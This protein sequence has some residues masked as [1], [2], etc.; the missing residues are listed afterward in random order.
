MHV[1]APFLLRSDAWT[2]RPLQE[3]LRLLL[4]ALPQGTGVKSDV[5]WALSLPLLRCLLVDQREQYTGI[6]MEALASLS[7]AAQSSTAC[8]EQVNTSWYRW[9]AALSVNSCLLSFPG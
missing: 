3:D 7:S 9:L 8:H 1:M 2:H 4:R 5:A 6:I